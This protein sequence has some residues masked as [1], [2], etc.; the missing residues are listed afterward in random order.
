[1]VAA[2]FL[3]PAEAIPLALAPFPLEGFFVFWASIADD[4]A[5]ERPTG[6]SAALDWC[7]VCDEDA[8]GPFLVLGTANAHAGI[9]KLSNTKRPIRFVCSL[10]ISFHIGD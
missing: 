2:D 1:M 10:N 9:S 6:R 7:E 5:D 8:P 3:P 4:W